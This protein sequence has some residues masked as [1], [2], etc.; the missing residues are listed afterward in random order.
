[1]RQHKYAGDYDH[2][3]FAYLYDRHENYRDD[4]ALIRRLLGDGGRRDVLEPHFRRQAG[5]PVYYGERESHFLEREGEVATEAQ[6]T[7]R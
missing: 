6:R 5:E 1:M 4:V 3:L 7:Q 2:P